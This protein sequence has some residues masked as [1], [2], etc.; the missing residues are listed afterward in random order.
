V[1]GRRRETANAP[2]AG[3]QTEWIAPLVGGDYFGMMPG[4]FDEASISIEVCMFHIAL[5][6]PGHPTF[7]LLDRL[8]A[9]AARGVAVRVLLDRDRPTD[10]YN[11]TIVNRQAKEYLEANGVPV[12]F[13]IEERLLHSKFVVVDRAT[14]FVGSHNWSTGSFFEFDDVTVAIASSPL[15]QQFVDRFDVLW[16]P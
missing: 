14:V 16:Q 2:A 4:V 1:D 10:P 13:D 5:G 9:A 12:R 15:A 8:A 6:N 3:V 7:Q 11:S